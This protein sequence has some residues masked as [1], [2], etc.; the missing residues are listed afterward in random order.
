MNKNK[1]AAP[2]A[3]N[4]KRDTL[5][6]AIGFCNQLVDLKVRPKTIIVSLKAQ[7]HLNTREAKAVYY[8]VAGKPV[9]THGGKS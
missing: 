6:E 1:N 5:A 4:R 2:L 7:Y 9:H 3:F 8:K